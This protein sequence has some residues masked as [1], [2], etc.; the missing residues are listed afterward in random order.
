MYT[1]KSLRVRIIANK[2][3]TS[4]KIYGDNNTRVV[5]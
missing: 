4:N 3:L 2:C 1:L 5:F